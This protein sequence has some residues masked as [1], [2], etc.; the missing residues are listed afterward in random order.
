M[1]EKSSIK[2]ILSTS[3]DK[4]DT[5]SLIDAA[6]FLRGSIKLRALKEGNNITFTL[7]DADGINGTDDKV[8]VISSTGGG[9]SSITNEISNG[10]TSIVIPNED[11][12][13]L[14][15][16]NNEYYWNFDT[17]GHLRLPGKL[18]YS[19]QVSNNGSNSTYC[20]S[21][22]DTV[23]YTSTNRYN[24]TIKVL[25]QLEGN[26]D[27]GGWD[28]QSCEI[29]VAKSFLNNNVAYSVYG[30][31]WCLRC[32]ICYRDNNIRLRN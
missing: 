27:G 18:Y 26:A 16:V 3:L 30:I 6:D 22:Q 15:T 9:G 17:N 25:V 21:S 32:C 7:E 10:T 29:I 12:D 1:T 14:I 31:Q 11:S 8:L 19:N 23:I 28:T 5:K 2:N 4:S 13:V 24:H 20:P